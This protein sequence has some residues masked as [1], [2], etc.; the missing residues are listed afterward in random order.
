VSWLIVVAGVI[1]LALA[2]HVAEQRKSRAVMQARRKLRG[3]PSDAQ[4]FS[5]SRE[6]RETWV[7]DFETM[8]L[9][10]SRSDEA[11]HVTFLLERG[12]DGI[13]QMRPTSSPAPAALAVPASMGEQ[14]EQRYQRYQRVSGSPPTASG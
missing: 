13:W 12:P 2:V 8:R 3:V 14:L 4:R 9:E 6:V 1:A 11:G 7:V 5:L 10:L